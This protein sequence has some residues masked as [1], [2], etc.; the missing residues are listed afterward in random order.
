MVVGT[1][2]C[3]RTRPAVNRHAPGT[4]SRFKD[5][6]R[7]RFV[8]YGAPRR[9]SVAETGKA[10]AE[11]RMIHALRSRR[12]LS[13]LVAAVLATAGDAA[14]GGPLSAQIDTSALPT[15]ELEEAWTLGGPNAPE[16]ESFT[17]MPLVA[18]NRHGTVFAVDQALGVARRFDETGAYLGSVGRLGEGP[19]EFGYILSV[20]FTG[21]SLWMRNASPPY[22]EFFDPGGEPLGRY[23]VEN[24]VIARGGMPAGPT[25]MLQGGARYSVG[26]VPIQNAGMGR[27]EVPLVL[28]RGDG[29]VD[30]LAQLTDPVGFYLPSG[31]GI[32][33]V[34]KDR[35]SPLHAP[36]VDGSGVWIA[37]WSDERPGRVELR[38]VDAA[39]GR[40]LRFSLD[41]EPLPLSRAVRDS[42]V[43]AAADSVRSLARRV[44]SLEVPDDLR[45]AAAEVLGLG[46]YLPPIRHMV[47]GADGSLWL[48]RVTAPNRSEWIVVDGGGKT[49]GRVELPIGHTLGAAALESVWTKR[50]DEFGVAYISRRGTRRGEGE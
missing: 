10:H 42:I 21:D 37:S 38:K 46:A 41:F 1:S 49:V 13:C 27:V 3:R 18:V 31:A 12:P 48:E 8:Q 22:V 15:L 34:V 5:P 39:A 47:P 25:A 28:T 35:P 9:D 43:G 32:G 6:R 44:G 50:R 17:G 45:T 23:T 14:V 7:P 36:A 29:T 4:V 2:E 20:G 30:T 33:T 19:G 24:P 26:V 40:E 16:H 11:W